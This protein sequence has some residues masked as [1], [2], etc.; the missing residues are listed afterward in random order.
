MGN[1]IIVEFDREELISKTCIRRNSSKQ[2]CLGC[3]YSDR[4]MIRCSLKKE[5]NF[6][7]IKFV[8][9]EQSNGNKRTED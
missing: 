3:D 4:K 7:I 8:Y 6:A 2:H 5:L 1:K 9:K